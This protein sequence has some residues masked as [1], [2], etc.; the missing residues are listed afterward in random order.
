[1]KKRQKKPFLGILISILIIIVCFLIYN[2]KYLFISD[3]VNT[4][5][6]IPD[7]KEEG[8]YYVFNYDK[9]DK[10]FQ[11][12]EDALEYAKNLDKA[13]ITELNKDEWLWN[14]FKEYIVYSGDIYLRDFDKYADAYEYAKVFKIG[15][16]CKETIND[17]VWEREYT[18]KG[19]ARIDTKTIYQLPELQRG[20]EVTSLAMLL[21]NRGIEVSKL[22]LASKVKKDTTKYRKINGKIYYGDPNKG[23]VGDMYSKSNNGYAVYHKPIYDLMNQYI[24]NSGIDL[25]GCEFND[26]YYFLDNGSPVWT[27]INVTYKKL[28][29]NDFFYWYSDEEKKIKVTS[30]EHSVII[31]GYDDNNIIINDPLV[32]IKTIEKNQF[33]ECW[34]QMGNQAITTAP[35]VTIR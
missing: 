21:K 1:M 20:C 10:E 15:R 26:L 25:T 17:V 16:I 24:D 11:N 34:E 8:Q 6:S 3:V 9:K 33:I 13:F 28:S 4:S 30:K 31:T 23:F 22:E 27:I 2:F 7:S 5:S 35:N 14:S 18:I 29:D 32:G 19:S 12:Y